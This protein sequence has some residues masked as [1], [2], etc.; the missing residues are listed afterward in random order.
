MLKYEAGGYESMSNASQKIVT[1]TDLKSY[2]FQSLHDLNTKS[3]CPVP[4][5]TIFYSSVVLGRFASS[6]AF[7][8]FNDGKVRDKILGMKLLEAGSMPSEAQKRTYLEVGDTALVLC[9][10]FSES[11]NKKLVDASYYAQLG[12]TAYGRL[13]NFFP[14]HLDVPDFYQVLAS[15]FEHVTSLIHMMAASTRFD[16]PRQLVFNKALSNEASDAELMSAGIV[17]PQQNKA[18]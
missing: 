14:R 9:G 16:D 12:K 15:S 3:L 4:Q 8:E 6:E 7:F 17:R 11:I 18:S 13:N 2:F 5:E 10:Y 1:S